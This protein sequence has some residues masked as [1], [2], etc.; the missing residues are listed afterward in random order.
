MKNWNKI[1]IAINEEDYTPTTFACDQYAHHVVM[2]TFLN[3]NTF[4][5]QRFEREWNSRKSDHNV[6]SWSSLLLGFHLSNLCF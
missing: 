2:D 5:K 3:A 4:L 1:L 6:T